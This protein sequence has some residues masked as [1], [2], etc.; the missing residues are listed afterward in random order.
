MTSHVFSCSRQRA[1]HI[2]QEVLKELRFVSF[3]LDNATAQMTAQKGWGFICPPQHIEIQ[4]H[5]LGHGIEVAVE[6]QSNMPALDFG[7][8]QFLEEEVIHRLR[9]RISR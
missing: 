9:E 3:H 8:A 4:L 7:R 1:I 5:Q 6:C 2:T